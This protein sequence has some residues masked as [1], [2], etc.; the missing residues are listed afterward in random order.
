[1]FPV[2]KFLYY[3]VLDKIHSEIDP[4]MYLMYFLGL[5]LSLN[6]FILCTNFFTDFPKFS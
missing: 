4:P 1:M 3:T 5:K 6:V 2:I